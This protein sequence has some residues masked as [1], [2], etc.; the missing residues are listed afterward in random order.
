M[1]VLKRPVPRLVI[2]VAV[3]LTMWLVGLFAS[4]R[5]LYSSGALFNHWVSGIRIFSEIGLL[6]HLDGE[7]VEDAMVESLMFL[8]VPIA[9]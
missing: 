9:A 6:S 2:C 3:F 1:N 8:W 5:L 4:V 7:G